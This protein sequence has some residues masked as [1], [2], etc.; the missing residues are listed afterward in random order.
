VLGEEEGKETIFLLCPP[1]RGLKRN[2]GGKEGGGQGILNS[3]G[4]K[5]EVTEGGRRQENH[6]LVKYL[7]K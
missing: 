2:T 4:G 6:V 1:K 3:L 5:T 7:G